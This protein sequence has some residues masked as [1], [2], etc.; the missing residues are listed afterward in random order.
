MAPHCRAT[1]GE[2]AEA[3]V[4]L[5]NGGDPQWRQKLRRAAMTRQRAQN[6]TSTPVPG[7]ASGPAPSD[8]FT[9]ASEPRNNPAR[10]Y[11]RASSDH[12]DEIEQLRENLEQMKTKLE[13]EQGRALH[14]SG[15]AIN[16]RRLAAEAQ[17]Q[18]QKSDNA[19]WELQEEV[20]RE[21]AAWKEAQF[22]RPAL[23]ESQ[24]RPRP[25]LDLKGIELGMTASAYR[26][27]KADL[28]SSLDHNLNRCSWTE[29]DCVTHLARALPMSFKTAAV[30]MAD[31]A[32]LFAFLDQQFLA[33]TSDQDEEEWEEMRIGV[34]TVAEF[35]TDIEAVA[36]RLEKTPEQ[37]TRCFVK[38]FRE[39]YPE[40]WRRLRIDYDGT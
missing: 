21:R 2:V 10:T 33:E 28:L 9:P 40:L 14:S 30:K 18:A 8:T 34:R 35:A 38:G 1:Q 5:M 6:L 37:I 31:T 17:R 20:T 4:E 22:Q 11:E 29:R 16:N 32:R 7:H 23:V 39:D 26:A 24:N 15:E 27:I 12:E 19:L 25:I 13:Q 36:E 3:I